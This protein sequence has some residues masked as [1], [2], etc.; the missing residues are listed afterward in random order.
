MRRA[1]GV[2]QP[3]VSPYPA[4]STFSAVGPD[5]YGVHGKDPVSQPL[6]RRV[7]DL[8]GLEEP[9]LLHYG[10]FSTAWLVQGAPKERDPFS[11]TARLALRNIFAIYSVGPRLL[12]P[13]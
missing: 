13:L 1:A 10:S 8:Y 11:S 3:R 4:D 12:R 6:R 9:Y 7:A 2:E 5:V